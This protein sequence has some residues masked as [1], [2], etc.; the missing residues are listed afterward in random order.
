LIGRR[1]GGGFCGGWH[2]C[3]RARRL[4]GRTGVKHMYIIT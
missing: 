3:K 4:G 2:G 1:V